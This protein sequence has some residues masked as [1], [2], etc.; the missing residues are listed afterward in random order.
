MDSKK[1]KLWTPAQNRFGVKAL[2][3]DKMPYLIGS[4][5]LISALSPSP[6]G[7]ASAP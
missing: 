4:Q 5:F 3:L 2:A 6:P 7:C 1:L